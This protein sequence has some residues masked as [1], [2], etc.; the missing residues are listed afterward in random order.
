MV[1]SMDGWAQSLNIDW[2][3]FGLWLWGFVFIGQRMAKDNSFWYVLHACAWA[4]VGL[5]GMFIVK[6]LFMQAGIV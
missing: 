4:F 3:L 5:H 1:H 2:F 6:A